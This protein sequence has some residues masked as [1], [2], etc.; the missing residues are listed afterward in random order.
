[1]LRKIAIETGKQ[2]DEEL[3]FPS[4]RRQKC[5]QEN[6]EK[7]YWRKEINN[8][9]MK[10]VLSGG[11]WQVIFQDNSRPMWTDESFVKANFWDAFISELKQVKKGLVDIPVGD[12]TVS[13]LS[14]HPNLHVH[15]APR[16]CFS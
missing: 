14:E 4:K 5:T 16:V 8:V 12:Y 10:E 3:A 13:H 11:Y 2:I 9:P 6:F 15:G 7:Y 1:M